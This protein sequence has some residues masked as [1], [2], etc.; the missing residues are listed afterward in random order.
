MCSHNTE[1][2]LSAQD[3][4]EIWLLL[5]S[6]EPKQRRIT[7]KH[8]L[9]IPRVK[10]E[11]LTKSPCSS[12]FPAALPNHSLYLCNPRVTLISQEMP[13][14]WQGCARSLQRVEACYCLTLKPVQSKKP[15]WVYLEW[16]AVCIIGPILSS[17]KGKKGREGQ[18]LP[19]CS[20]KKWGDGPTSS[21][22]KVR[23]ESI[24]SFSLVFSSS[25][26][27]AS[28]QIRL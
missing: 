19:G 7:C 16:T 25:H 3:L 10:N 22:V 26:T 15:F 18:Y 5:F 12:S 13:L 6:S 4:W 21:D 20:S 11:T 2:V 23:V 14:P 27:Y 9:Y 1:K 28:L 8:V 17:G 24:L